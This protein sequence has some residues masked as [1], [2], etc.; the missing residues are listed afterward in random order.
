VGRGPSMQSVARAAG[1]SASTVSNAYNRPE[2]LSAQVRARVL[3]VAA[4]QGYAGPDPAARSL[5]SR[6]SGAVGV[7]FTVPLPYAFTDPYCAALLTGLA[8]VAEQARTSLLLIPIAAPSASGD[9]EELR[10]SVQAVRQAGVDGAVADGI[11]DGHPAL[12]VLASRGLPI[13]RSV[14]SPAAG[15]RV[16]IDDYAA[17]REVGQHLAGLGHR[18]VTVLVDHATAP[19]VEGTDASAGSGV[20]ESSLYPYSRL[21][22]AGVRDGLGR[23]GHVRAVNAG[24]NTSQAGRAAAVEV[25]RR[26]DRPS[27]IV[28]I[29]DVLA[30]GVLQ[31]ARE[32]Q[33]RPGQDLSV[34]GF[35]DVPA[36]AA[37]GLTTVRQPVQD[38]GRLMGRMLLDPTFTERRVQLATELVVRATTGPASANT[39]APPIQQQ[40]ARP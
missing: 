30:L 19:P 10:R 36:A 9:E 23:N 6:R 16:L 11:H 4:E 21:R 13:V 28:A 32:Q 1:V 33:L 38:K 5:R 24:L 14:D 31:A 34:T 39:P 25:L 8:E 15:G 26:P 17:G 29:S 12:R 3:A 18:D 7:L 37:A 20:D 2:Q 35:D 27:A 40:G 22:L